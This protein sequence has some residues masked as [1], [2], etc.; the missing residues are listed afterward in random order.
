MTKKR[1]KMEF[2]PQSDVNDCGITCLRMIA[3]Y[4]GK[5]KI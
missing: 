3:K 1:R 5:E 2:I 4:Y